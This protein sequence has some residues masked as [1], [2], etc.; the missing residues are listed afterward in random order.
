MKVNPRQGRNQG[1]QA[2]INELKS[3]RERNLYET[4]T[5]NFYRHPDLLPFTRRQAKQKLKDKAAIRWVN[6]VK[7]LSQNSL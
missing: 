2:R 3:W 5:I 1:R 4:K 7:R 6:S